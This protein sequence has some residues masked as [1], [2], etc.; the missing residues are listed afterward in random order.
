MLLSNLVR[1]S[2]SE[3]ARVSGCASVIAS[4]ASRP[5]H[6]V[7]PEEPQQN[8]AGETVCGSESSKQKWAAYYCHK[9]VHVIESTPLQ[10][11][12]PFHL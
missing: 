7:R 10:N 12:W 9:K 11:Q 6:D 2:A 5:P 8:D 3:G 1:S 4:F